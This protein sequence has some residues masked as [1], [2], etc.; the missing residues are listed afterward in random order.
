[1][2]HEHSAGGGADDHPI[3]GVKEHSKGT[4]RAVRNFSL[5]SR[6][7]MRGPWEAMMRY[8]FQIQKGMPVI[9]KDGKNLGRIEK[10]LGT[11]AII[12]S[13][14]RQP[15]SERWI[16]RLI[17][18]EI[19]LARSEAQ[20]RQAWASGEFAVRLPVTVGERQHG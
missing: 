6:G 17:E 13:G 8:L 16:S 18:G 15:I 7:H 5:G 20:I 4:N 9:T 14:S 1:L 3:L 12:L 10:V 19:Y 2:N 11:D